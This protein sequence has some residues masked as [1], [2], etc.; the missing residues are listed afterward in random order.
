MTPTGMM[1]LLE[2]T[3]LELLLAA[4]TLH[5]QQRQKVIYCALTGKYTVS[6]CILK[7]AIRLTGISGVSGNKQ[8]DGRLGR[9]YLH[10]QDF[11]L[12][13][14]IWPRLRPR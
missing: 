1:L 5:H 12:R 10:L 8:M 7:T 4:P 2:Y 9:K 13:Q 11:L 3:G 14:Q 6:K